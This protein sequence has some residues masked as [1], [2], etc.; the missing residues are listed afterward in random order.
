MEGLLDPI[1]QDPRLILGQQLC[2]LFLFVFWLALV[3]WTWRDA[4]KRGAMAWFWALVVLIFSI[5]GWAIYMV[6]RPPEYLEDVRERQLE[7]K[8][9]EAALSRDSGRCPSCF[10]PV[11]PD[12]LVCPNC[13]RTLRKE[14]VECGRALDMKWSVC[15]YCKTRQAPQGAEGT[16]PAR[17]RAQ[18]GAPA[19]RAS[20]QKPKTADGE[21]TA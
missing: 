12:Y 21:S 1:L 16:A 11:E 14:C 18:R 7:I 9:R 3:F 17:G 8:A 20:A 5:A 2:G 6:V 15:P 19:P 10:R 4:T 13:M